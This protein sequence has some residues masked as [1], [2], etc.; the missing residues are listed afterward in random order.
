MIGLIAL[1]EWLLSKRYK[2]PYFVY[3]LC[4]CVCFVVSLLML[5]L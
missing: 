4:L 2:L 1:I 5:A 3:Y